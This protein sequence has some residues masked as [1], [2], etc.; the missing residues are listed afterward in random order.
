MPDKQALDDFL[1]MVLSGRHDQAIADFYADDCTMQENLGE[2]RR[3]R[4]A[5]VAREKA[6]LARF[7]DVRTTVVPPVFV[8]GDFV[9]IHWIFE[10][11]R[12]DGGVVRIEELAHQRWDG[13]KMAEERF[14]YDPAQ[15]GGMRAS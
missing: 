9:V 14:Y 10:F 13:N 4:E 6:T 12:A 2:V 7:K 3:G 11:V 15:M 5:A 1:A 8:N